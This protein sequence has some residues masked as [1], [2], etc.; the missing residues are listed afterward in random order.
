MRIVLSFVDAH[1]FSTDW[2]DYSVHFGI[3]VLATLATLYAQRFCRHR[4]HQFLVWLALSAVVTVT[5]VNL[6]G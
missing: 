5:T 4:L 1:D 6:V 3:D 2:L